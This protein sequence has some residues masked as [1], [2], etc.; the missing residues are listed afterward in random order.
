LYAQVLFATVESMKN[1]AAVALGRLG[2]LKGGKARAEAL[3]PERRKE[4]AKK[5]IAARW[6]KAKETPKG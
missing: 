1:R 2:G 6:A 3:T 5:A 4:I